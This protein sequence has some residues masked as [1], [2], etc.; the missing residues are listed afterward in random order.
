MDIAA[1]LEKFRRFESA[2]QRLDPIDDFVLWYWAISSAGAALMNAALHR[3]GTLDE[4]RHFAT[5]IP[6]VYAV[7]DGDTTWHYE[8][9]TRC[10]LIHIGIP[11]LPSVPAR[12]APAYRAMEAIEQWRNPCVRGEHP[13]TA[14]LVSDILENYA[15]VL[16]VAELFPEDRR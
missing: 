10:D 16:Q 9:G 1:H 6:D 12:V 4:N 7:A 5:Q 15:I 3:L 13:V 8:I 2:R 14:Q 11:A